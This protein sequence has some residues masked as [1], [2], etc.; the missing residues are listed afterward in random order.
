[1]ADYYQMT[2]FELGRGAVVPIRK[3]LHFGT[4]YYDCPLCGEAVGIWKDPKL[5]HVTNGFIYKRDQCKNGH[6][7]DWSGVKE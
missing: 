1:M 2:I 6:E 5:D 3:I 4:Y 7:I